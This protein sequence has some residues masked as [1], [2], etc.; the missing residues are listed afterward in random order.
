MSYLIIGATSGVGRA[1]AERFA[2]AAQPLLIVSSDAR[3]LA[4]LASDLALRWNVRVRS[5]AID[6]A[7]DPLPLQALD[8]ALDALPPLR[9]ILLPAGSSRTDDVPGQDP[10]AHEA[11]TRVNY[12]SPCRIVDH[13]LPRLRAAGRE[14]LLIGF[15]SVAAERGRSRNVAYAAA[16][17]ALKSY[18][19]SLRHALA[20]DGVVVQY[21]TLGYMD[22]NLAFGQRTPLPK[23]DPARLA[24]RVYRRR[25]DDL[26]TAYYPALWRPICL[27]LKVVPWAV[28]RR[29]SF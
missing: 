26:G 1:L 18:F 11:I 22:T 12:A 19:E 15:G 17:R 9:G 29:L 10:R 24:E 7:A 8:E 5:L 23:G 21:Y 25:R 6:L 13:C 14:G 27:V 20:A 16:K 4:A 2:A 28:F 3:D